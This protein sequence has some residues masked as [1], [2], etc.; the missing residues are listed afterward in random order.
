MRRFETTRRV[1]HSARNM[2]DLVGDVERY[3]EFVPLCSHLRIRDRQ[4]DDEHT[5]L[6]CDMTAAYKAF[7][8]TFACQVT[9]KGDNSAIMV[10]YLDG[11]FRSLDNVWRFEALDETSCNV[12]FFI[13]YEFRSRALQLVAGAVFD[14]AFEKFAEAFEARA[15]RVYGTGRRSA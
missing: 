9:L 3:P 13:E 14:R 8:D 1:R 10:K 12:G 2:F 5:V 6:I 4:E 7:S 15:D 11:P